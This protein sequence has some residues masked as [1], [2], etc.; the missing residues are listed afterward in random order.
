MPA[1]DDH[2][3]ELFEIEPSRTRKKKPSA[4]GAKEKSGCGCVLWLIG[5][6]LLFGAL[7]CGGGAYFVF[8]AFLSPTDFPPQTQEYSEARKAFQTKLVKEGPAPQEW[9]VQEAPPEVEVVE[10]QSGELTLKAWVSRVE[11][12]AVPNGAAVPNA[13]DEP[14]D[15]ELPDSVAPPGVEPPRV[16]GPPRFDPPRFRLPNIRFPKL[17]GLSEQAAKKPVRP[18]EKK[19]AVLFLHGGFAFGEEDWNQTQ[20]FRDEGYVVL[21]PLLRGENGQP[22]SYSMFFHEVDDVL[23]A[24]E[25]LAARPDVDPQRIYVAGHSA[26]GTLAMLAAMA[27]DRFAAAASVSGSPDQV[28]WSRTQPDAIPFDPEN[29]SEFAIRSPLAWPKSFRCPI[30]LYY[31]DEEFF[32]ARTSKRMEELSTAAGRDVKAIEV[33]GDH[34]SSVDVAIPRAIEFFETKRKEPAAAH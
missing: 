21:I 28:V 13:A 26:G 16:I 31:G 8:K 24:A 20:P 6:A 1:Y 18:G 4:P 32:F 11:E 3:D 34:L 30:R 14:A 2:Q 7:V 5:G 9:L 10:F 12:A 19:P 15:A 23:A 25:V 17:D 27:S 33:E 22:G 29:R